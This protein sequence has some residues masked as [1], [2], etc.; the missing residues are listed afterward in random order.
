MNVALI[1]VEE[2]PTRK[3]ASNNLDGSHTDLA[4]DPLHIIPP[5]LFPIISS[6]RD[7]ANSF[8]FDPL[9]LFD[10]DRKINS[11]TAI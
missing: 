3:N 2:R 6:T 10:W 7:L 9:D 8:T 11:L 5:F 1:L 4:W